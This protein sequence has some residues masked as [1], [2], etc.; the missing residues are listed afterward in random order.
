M[1]KI[2]FAFVMFADIFI[3]YTNFKFLNDMQKYL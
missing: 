3:L 2:T 1:I